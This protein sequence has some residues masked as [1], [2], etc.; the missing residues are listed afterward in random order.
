M[1]LLRRNPQM[2]IPL[3]AVSI[4]KPRPYEAPLLRTL[5]SNQAALFLVGHAYIGHQ[6]ARDLLELLFPM[7]GALIERTSAPLPHR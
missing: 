3:R 6:G 7:Q 1:P 2:E 4:D 5:S